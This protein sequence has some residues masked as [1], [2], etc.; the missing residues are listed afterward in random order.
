[1]QFYKGD[2]KLRTFPAIV[3]VSAGYGYAR[4]L[5]RFFVHRELKVARLSIRAAYL[6][7]LMAGLSPG[8]N[9]VMTIDNYSRLEKKMNG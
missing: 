4:S 2:I 5:N 8:S 3:Q 9:V 7:A 6:N 1:M